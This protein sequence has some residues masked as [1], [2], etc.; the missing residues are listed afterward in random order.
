MKLDPTSP[1]FFLPVLTAVF[2][3][4]Y[5]LTLQPI[6]AIF[7]LA[8]FLSYVA[9]DFVAGTEKK[10]RGSLVE[11]IYAV[12]AASAV[13]LILSTALST[14]SPLDV[15]TSCS[16][17][18]YLDRGDLVVVQGKAVYTAPLVTYTNQLPQVNINRTNCTIAVRGAALET[19]QCTSMITVNNGTTL[20]QIAVNRSQVSS[21]DVIVFESSTA[22]LV[23]HRAVLALSDESGKLTYLT[24]GDNNQVIDQE[25]GLDF[26]KPEKIHGKMLARVPLIGYLR[27]FLAGQFAEPLGCDTLV[28]LP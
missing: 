8:S 22:G 25:A 10:G 19:S 20:L 4:I 14:P 18:P 21:N 27:L 7:C 15:V 24:K 9:L 5:L 16:M 3:A 28:D 2:L 6:F 11:I 17:K 23:I 26:V 13:W 1:N 12:L